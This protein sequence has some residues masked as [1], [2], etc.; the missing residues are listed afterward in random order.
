MKL[1]KLSI[2]ALLTGMM[3]ISCSKEYSSEHMRA[4]TGNWEFANSELNYNGYLDTIYQI[5]GIG[6]NVLYI[7]GKTEDGSQS[8]Q[9]K[10]YGDSIVP[11]T[12][13]ASKYQASFNYSLPFKTIYSASGLTG[14]FIVNLDVLDS[15]KVQGTF[16]GTVIDSTSNLIQ[17]TNGKFSTY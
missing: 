17:L 12:Y 11:G 10:L 14:E 8:F 16:S 9:L 5:K 2:F 15:T 7:L 1:F 6:I 13:Y 4:S 3:L